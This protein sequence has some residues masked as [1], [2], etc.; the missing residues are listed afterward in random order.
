V[1]CVGRRASGG[2]TH[3]AKRTGARNT[4]RCAT[5]APEMT[6]TMGV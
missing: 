5:H 3:E 4:Y 1:T 6:V 2:V